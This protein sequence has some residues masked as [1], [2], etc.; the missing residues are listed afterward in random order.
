MN[1]IYKCP[2]CGKTYNS[3]QLKKPKCPDCRK[4]LEYVTAD[5]N[6]DVATPK[7]EQSQSTSKATSSEPSISDLIRAQNKTTFAVRS[8]ALYF[9]ISLQ[10]SMIGGGLIIST[11]SNKENYDYYGN[12]ESG[13]SS[14]VTF[15]YFIAFI[16]FLVAVLVGRNELNKSKV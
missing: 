10:T 12:L 2:K 11:M 16:G 6:S 3:S 7:A 13:P 15:G 14:L 4:W 8:L 1:H 5:P 9:F